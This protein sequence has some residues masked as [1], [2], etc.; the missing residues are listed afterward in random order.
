MRTRNEIAYSE[1][2]AQIMKACFNCYAENGL[3]GTG[4]AAR[5]FPMRR[6]TLTLQT[7]TI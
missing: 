5:A 1:K 3:H 7:L 6:F 4:I 2:K